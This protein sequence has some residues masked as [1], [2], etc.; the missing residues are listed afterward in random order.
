MITA[1]NRV[2]VAAAALFGGLLAG[3][4]INRIVVQLPAWHETSVVAWADYTRAAD[5]GVGMVF[6]P[7]LGL[8]ALLLTI[9]AAVAFRV[10]QT[11]PR[12]G[13]VAAYIAA[14]LATA[15]L[16]V[17]GRVLAPATHS[18]A[19]IVD[20]PA[21]LQSAFNSFVRWWDFKALLHAAAFAA[22][23]WALA[24]LLPARAQDNARQSARPAGC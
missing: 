17:T 12:S 7:I 20:D 15:A 2:V 23:L 9:A 4:V 5:L 1:M 8:S 6:Y 3:P 24:S 13:A 18:L 14:V 22:N 16:L 11:M 21:A 19:H 10:D